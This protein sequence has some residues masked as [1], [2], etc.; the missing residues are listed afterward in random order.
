MTQP[1][2]MSTTSLRPSFF[3]AAIIGGIVVIAALIGWAL[4]NRAQ[5][6]ARSDRQQFDQALIATIYGNQYRNL[7]PT[8]EHAPLRPLHNR[9]PALAISKRLDSVF[10]NYGKGHVL[11]IWV[12]ALTDRLRQD[13][14]LVIY[15]LM[16]F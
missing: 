7:P 12:E 10:A 4:D 1:V 11:L 5:T 9:S 13:F 15:R 14:L 2:P 3:S 8:P 6:T 16:V